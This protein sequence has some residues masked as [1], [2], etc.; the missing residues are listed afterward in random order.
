MGLDIESLK[1]ANV[2]RL[3][4]H[5]DNSQTQRSRLTKIVF[6]SEDMAIR[7]IKSAK[8]LSESSIEYVKNIRL[9]R[10]LC[11]SDRLKRK[12][13][14]EEIRQKTSELSSSD[15]QVWKYIIRGDKVVKI[16]KQTGSDTNL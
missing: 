13:L 12:S 10:D 2:L 3:G 11:Q 9:F 5:N 1:N 15:A 16:K 7:V 4:K 6:D 8:K 14:V